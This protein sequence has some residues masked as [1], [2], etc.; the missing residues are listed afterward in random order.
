[1]SLPDA[2]AAMLRRWRASGARV[3]PPLAP[4]TLASSEVRHRVRLPDDL[5]A[6]WAVCDGMED[7]DSDEQMWSFWSLDRIQAERIEQQ[8]LDAQEDEDRRRRKLRPRVRHA[9]RWG[10][11][12][13]L[14]RS[15]V[16]SIDLAP[17]GA[18]RVTGLIP[19]HFDLPSFE[20][21][22]H[23]YLHET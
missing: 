18:G 3:R 1:M 17:A 15:D 16:M 12:D 7:T 23:F 4:Y 13:W 5:R 19:H 14:L 2:L 21:F 8:Q 10:F 9:A 6:Y 22:L 11:C 20:A